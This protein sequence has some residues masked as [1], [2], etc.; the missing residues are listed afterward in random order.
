MD[1]FV[2]GVMLLRIFTDYYTTRQGS[3]RREPL[4][5]DARSEQEFSTDTF[6]DIGGSLWHLQSV[7]RG[8]HEYRKCGNTRHSPVP[9]W[10]AYTALCRHS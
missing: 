5:D 9:Q 1:S 7:T 4:V 3:G 2:I 8:H 6:S 10:G